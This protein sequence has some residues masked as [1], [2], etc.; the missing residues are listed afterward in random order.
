MGGDR[1]TRKTLL[2]SAALLAGFSSY[3]GPSSAAI[4]SPGAPSHGPA[5][6]VMVSEDIKLAGARNF[7]DNMTQRGIAFLSNTSLS[8]TQQEQEF[9]ALLNDTFDMNTIARFSLGR[10]WRV[11]DAAQKKE[12]LTLFNK[13]VLDVYSQRFGEYQGQN[14]E[15]VSAREAGKRDAMVKSVISGN[16]MPDI[17]VDWRVR[18]KDGKYKIIDVMIEGVSM[19]QTQRSDFSSVI[20]RGGG[21]IEVLLNHLRGKN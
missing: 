19:A 18:Y 20:Q 1:M 5:S 3:A 8:P 15:V 10:Y 11:A 13:M 17:D 14:I 4:V 9:R 21:N 6:L 12:Y 2:L 7:V 16:G